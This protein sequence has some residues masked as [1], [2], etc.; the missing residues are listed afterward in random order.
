ME[1]FELP[2]VDRLG[3]PM[4][5]SRNTS[6]RLIYLRIRTNFLLKSLSFIHEEP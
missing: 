5:A 2:L 6:S 1:A 4:T 3:D